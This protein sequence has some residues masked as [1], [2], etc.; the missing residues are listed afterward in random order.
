MKNMI[1]RSLEDLR[2][3]RANSQSKSIVM[4]NGGF[5]LFHV[6]HLELIKNAKKKA[7]IL[8]VCISSNRALA[9]GKDSSRPVIGQEERALIVDAIKYVD[10]V[11]I[12]IDT[13]KEDFTTW[14]GYN[15]RPDLIISGD[16]RWY[17]NSEEV[18][19]LGIKSEIMPR[20][21]TSTTSIINKIKK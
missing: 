12:N 2:T 7:D 15:L 10:Y 19:A 11:F 14:P 16:D 17:H 6:S 4:L 8:V 18:K 20:G 3:I 1:I 5:D 13:S 21:S 9:T